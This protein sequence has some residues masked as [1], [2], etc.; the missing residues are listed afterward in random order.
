MISSANGIQLAFA[1]VS[2]RASSRPAK[3]SWRGTSP[4]PAIRSRCRGVGAQGLVIDKRAA[5][6]QRRRE[7]SGNSTRSRSRA[8]YAA[9]GE[10]PDDQHRS[11]QETSL[12]LDGL[13]FPAIAPPHPAKYLVANDAIFPLNGPPLTVNLTNASPGNA[14]LTGV[15][16]LGVAVVD[17]G[18]PDRALVFNQELYASAFARAVGLLRDPARGDATSR[19]ASLRAPRRPGR[20]VRPAALRLYDGHP[21]GG[22]RRHPPSE[23]PFPGPPWS[24]GCRPTASPS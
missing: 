1:R 20:A 8:P 3:R 22:R 16:M 17:V 19:R 15:L 11:S 7:P 14:G 6:H 10:H 9:D 21:L 18:P 12:D 13:I 24:S 23:V 4:E 5:R 2:R